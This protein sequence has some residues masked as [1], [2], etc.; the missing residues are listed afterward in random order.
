MKISHLNDMNTYEKIQRDMN[1]YNFESPYS[2]NHQMD[3]RACMCVCL[4]VCM[5]SI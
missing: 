3:V 1:A 5:Y 2:E 4:C